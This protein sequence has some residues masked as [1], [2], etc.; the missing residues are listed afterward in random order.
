MGKATEQAQVRVKLV[1]EYPVIMRRGASSGFQVVGIAV[2]GDN[3]GVFAGGPFFTRIVGRL[4]H[5]GLG[6]AVGALGGIC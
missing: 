5:G 3:E 2:L 6:P 1:L 4:V